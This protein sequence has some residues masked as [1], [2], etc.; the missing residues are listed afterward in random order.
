MAP[1]V[2][3]RGVGW[4]SCQQCLPFPNLSMC[5]SCELL[6]SLRS[7]GTVFGRGRTRYHPARIQM[8]AMLSAQLER[9]M[10]CAPLDLEWPTA[11]SLHSLYHASLPALP[12]HLL[13]HSIALPLPSIRKYQN[14]SPFVHSVFSSLLSMSVFSSALPASNQILLHRGRRPAHRPAGM[15]TA[16]QGAPTSA[17]PP[18]GTVLGQS[19]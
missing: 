3:L 4:A 16:G 9:G 6:C 2:L 17:R 10:R 1:R 8:Q 19:L 12:R 14:F 18:R 5:A 7:I 15:H 13:G 11:P